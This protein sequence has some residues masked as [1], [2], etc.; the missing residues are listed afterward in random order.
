M[1]AVVEYKKGHFDIEQP[2]D[3]KSILAVEQIEAYMRLF[4][5]KTRYQGMRGFLVLGHE[6]SVFRL[7]S[8]GTVR[9]VETVRTDVLTLIERAQNNPNKAKMGHLSQLAF[10]TKEPEIPSHLITVAR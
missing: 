9:L 4:G 1:I 10:D 6:T 8:N 5:R 2:P 3:E 7:K